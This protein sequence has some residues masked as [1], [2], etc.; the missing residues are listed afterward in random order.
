MQISTNSVHFR[1]P[2]IGAA[3]CAI[4]LSAA[5]TVSDTEAPPL[6]GP[7]GF[8]L[9]FSMTAS[10]EILPRDGESVSTIRVEARLNDQPY[11]NQTLVLTT[12]AGRLSQSEVRTDGSGRAAFLYTAPSVNEPVSQAT[13][14]ITAVQNGDLANARSDSIRIA[15][16]GPDVPVAS[17]TTTP[18][19]AAPG[20]AFH[21]VITFDATATRLGTATCGSSCTYSW[22]FGDS[23]SG[24]DL[25]VQHQYANSG[26]F[27]V[28]LTVTTAT[29]TSN[30][31]TKPVVIAP[32]VLTTP[33]FTFAP[34][35]SLQPKCM[36][37]A[38]SSAPPDGVEIVTR[39]W[40]FGDG[41]SPVSTSDAA[42]DHVFPAN[43]NPVT[44]N[45]RLRLTDNFGRVS[46]TTKQVAVP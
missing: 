20:A 45:V 11:A 3:L 19:T 34:C 2:R 15:V 7:S 40:D 28:T 37:L 8:G 16:I 14:F 18:S 1:W 4:A 39:Y 35:A 46:T 13:I 24:S 41:S 5:C 36:T 9:S 42:I 25:V 30:S 23:S 26:V 44:Y 38:D 31:V 10:P 32:P 21:S 27:N 12:S 29:G 17:F 6:G 33:D 43:A 22:N